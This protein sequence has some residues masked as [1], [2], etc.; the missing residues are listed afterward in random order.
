MAAP[1]LPAAELVDY[2]GWRRPRPAPVT[3][4]Q[5]PDTAALVCELCRQF[6]ALGWVSG[7]GGGIS[8]RGDEGIFVAPSGVQKERIVPADVFVLDKH[9]LDRPVIT[10]AAADTSLRLSECQPLFWNAYRL[11][12]A[13]AVLHS[14]S[15]W[16]VLA[17]RLAAPSGR[18][19]L[20]LHGFEM[21]KGLRGKGNTEVVEFP[22]IAN[23]PH[24]AELTESM[25]SAM[26]EHNDVDAVIVAGHGLYVWGRS[27]IEAKTQ[28]ECIDWLARAVVEYHRAGVWAAATGEVR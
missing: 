4:V 6:Y 27:W 9:V 14:H 11:R 12:D 2:Q 10:R 20:R 13:G 28:A 26:S 22:I 17:A 19:V 15:L 18:G 16:P 25:V 5:I 23:T 24:E 8:I 7:T 3:V 21:L 1:R